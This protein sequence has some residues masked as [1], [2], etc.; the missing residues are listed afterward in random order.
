[1][2]S[3]QK[4]DYPDFEIIVL[5]DAPFSDQDISSGGE[6][7]SNNKVKIIPTGE[8]LPAKKRDFALEVAKGNIFAFIDDDVYLKE[9][10]LKEAVKN[11]SDPEVAA[12][13]GPAVTPPEDSF[14]QL[15][16]G[17][18]FSNS[19]VSGNFVYRYLPKKRRYVDDYPSCNL[20]VRRE[21]FKRL[22]GF[23]TKFWP[24]EDTKLCLEITKILGK[25]I[26]YDPKV[27]IFHHRRSLF[28]P[29][30]RQVASYALHRGFFVKKYPQTS[31]KFSYFVPS[32]FVLALLVGGM[33]SLKSQ[34]M[35]ALYLFYL[36]FYLLM[37]FIFS[38]SRE[39]RLTP[40]IAFGIITTHITYG[41]YF[42]KG[43]SLKEIRYKK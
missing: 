11:F 20:L 38:V 14:W 16:S 27:L 31:L 29:H 13:G 41:F 9:D 35:S 36:G 19:L 15:A 39:L 33:L 25:K 43:L 2:D 6:A 12:V 3:C 42:I 18:V 7:F 17:H 34:A 40:V 5:P 28:L 24:G 21:V 22:G 37:V 32:L 4:L 26:V 10:W 1:M 23:N 8:A 30:L